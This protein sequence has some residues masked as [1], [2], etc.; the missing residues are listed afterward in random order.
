MNGVRISRAT[1]LVET[2]MTADSSRLTA[3]G[4]DVDEMRIVEDLPRAKTLHEQESLRRAG[5]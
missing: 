2:M 5:V 1:W 3:Y 4:P